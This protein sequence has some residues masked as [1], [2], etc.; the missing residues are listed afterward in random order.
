MSL[1]GFKADMCLLSTSGS[2]FPLLA[3]DVDL[4]ENFNFLC[5]AQKAKKNY[6]QETS[7]DAYLPYDALIKCKEGLSLHS[8]S[9]ASFHSSTV[10][11]SLNAFSY[12]QYKCK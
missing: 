4:M 12:S 6:L 5:Q 2:L 10:Y 7:A 8:I 11:R 9:R 3:L 1:L